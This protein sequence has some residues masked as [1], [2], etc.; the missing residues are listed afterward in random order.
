MGSHPIFVFDVLYNCYQ[1]RTKHFFPELPLLE[2]MEPVKSGSGKGKRISNSMEEAEKTAPEIRLKTKKCG[3]GPFGG[4]GEFPATEK[5][6]DAK[7]LHA[8]YISRILSEP[9]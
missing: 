6:R 7:T 9:R 1:K 3:R 5:K 2:L 4:G 8:I